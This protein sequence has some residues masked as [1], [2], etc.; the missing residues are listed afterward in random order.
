MKKIASILM[1]L[2]MAGALSACGGNQESAEPTAAESTAAETEAESTVESTTEEKAKEPVELELEDYGYT[3]SQNNG[4]TSISYAV[5]IKN[6][7]TK[8]AVDY[9]VITTTVRGADGKILTTDDMTLMCIAAD[10]TI[11]YGGGL[12]Y[13]SDELPKSVD[14]SVGNRDDNFVLQMLSD[15]IPQEYI[16]IEN[17]SE[18]VGEYNTNYTGEITNNSDTDMRSAAVSVIFTK[19]GKLLG[20]TTSYVDDIGAGETKAFEISASSTVSDYDAY[21]IHA[22]Q[23]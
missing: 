17:T 1:A 9:P 16:V 21:E 13:E 5:K 19:E 10:D 14:F 23:W 8:Y 6:P 18:I 4:R 15:A 2:I 3:V 22:I 12:T 7:N 20:G 11:T